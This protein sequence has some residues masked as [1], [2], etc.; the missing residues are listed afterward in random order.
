M[1]EVNT[2]Q[3]DGTPT[4]IDLGV[5]DLDRAMSFYGALFGWDFE[6]GPAEAGYYT[7]CLLRGRP[8][9]GL[10]QLGEPNPD[11]HWWNVYLATADCDGTAKRITA[12]GGTL[13][14]EPMDVLDAGR[15]VTARDPV[16]AMF[17][18]WQGKAHLGCQLVNEPNTL[19][20]ND[21]VTGDPAAARSFYPAIFEFTLDGNQ[22]MPG[23]DFT[24][25]R[26][27]DGH[28]IG[29]II[30]M[31]G[32]AASRWATVFEVDDTDNAVQRAVA[33][34]GTVGEVN[35]TLYGRTASLTDPFGAEFEVITRPR[36]G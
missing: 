28:E 3:P 15:M 9:A 29:G 21:L 25:L 13:L 35:D 5:P 6:V 31:P 34:G 2:N 36:N 30:G 19:V 8:V 7:N 12:A 11:G 23:F 17:A 14:H 16:G 27:P 4:W 20:R 10:S 18:L 33:E 22:D 32:G 24:F 26:R 1:S